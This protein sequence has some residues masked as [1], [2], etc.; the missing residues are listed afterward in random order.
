MEEN[1]RIKFAYLLKGWSFPGGNKTLLQETAQKIPPTDYS[2]EMKGSLFCPECSAPLFRSP[3]GKAYAAN[4]RKAFFAHAR[5]TKTECNLRVK[6]AE[7]KNYENEEEARKAIENDELVVVQSFMKEKPLPPQV[8]GPLFYDKDPNEDQAGKPSPIAIGRHSGEEFKLPSK[9]T[10]VRGLCRSFDHNLNKYFILPGQRAAS[11][12]KDQLISVKNVNET[13]DFL[14]LYAGR[15]TSSS[16][17]GP[18]PQ[19]IRMTFLKFPGG[20]KYKDF[21][22]KATDELSREH[23]IDN[24]SKGRIVIVYGKVTESGL[25]LCIPNIGWGEIALLPEKYEY[26]LKDL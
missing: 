9:I 25:G 17:M 3:E 12:L 18:T 11:T 22:I 2:I 15:I 4:G 24:H 8:D 20:S 10:T 26:L 1:N 14:R 5:G 6:Q 16:N 7:G 23:G 19:N 13:S 21:C